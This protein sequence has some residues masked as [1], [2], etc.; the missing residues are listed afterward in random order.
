M[1]NRLPP[2]LPSP[3]EG[4][5][6]T[7]CGWLHLQRLIS[8]HSFAQQTTFRS[9]RPETS[10]QPRLFAHQPPQHHHHQKAPGNRESVFGEN[11]PD[12]FSGTTKRRRVETACSKHQQHR[13]AAVTTSSHFPNNLRVRPSSIELLFTCHGQSPR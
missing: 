7:S 12:P 8:Q 3:L 1:V 10:F 13:G 4:K 6:V 11:R 5:R 2:R 9:S